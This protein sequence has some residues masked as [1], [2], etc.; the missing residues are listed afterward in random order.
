MSRKPTTQTI[1]D[2][3]AARLG[4]VLRKRLDR[5]IP[6][7]EALRETLHERAPLLLER[8][9]RDSSGSSWA[10]LMGL[11]LIAA[12][13]YGANYAAKELTGKSLLD[14]AREQLSGSTGTSYPGQQ[15]SDEY[16]VRAE[17]RASRPTSSPHQEEAHGTPTH[18][19]TATEG[20][21]GAGSTLSGFSTYEEEFRQH[22]RSTYQD[23]DRAYSYYEPAYR[24]GYQYATAGRHGA[25]EYAD[26]EAQMRRD[27]E[28]E[29]GPNTYSDVEGAVRYGFNQGRTHLSENAEVASPTGSS[30][31]ASGDAGSLVRE[32]EEDKSTAP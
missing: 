24:H 7:D 26:L 12:A 16:P 11:G 15:H 19:T 9:R 5:G 22:H 17:P 29:H 1:D 27:Y 14:L 28:S 18:P 13:G 32:E 10:K 3:Y 8:P 2:T 25:G 6:L 31:T 20:V 21:S 4:H 23:T 30:Q